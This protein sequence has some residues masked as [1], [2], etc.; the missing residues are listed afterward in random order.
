M[1]LYVKRVRVCDE[2]PHIW[3][4]L[5]V[6]R[7]TMVYEERCTR[8]PCNGPEASRL[9]DHPVVRRTLVKDL[10]PLYKDEYP[11]PI[12]DWCGLEEVSADEAS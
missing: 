5:A 9:E 10:P 8:P 1:R 11:C 6:Y 12:P 2:C 3:S 7:G 4:G